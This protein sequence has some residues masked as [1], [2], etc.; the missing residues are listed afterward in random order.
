MKTSNTTSIEYL[1]AI[2]L[3]MISMVLI[4]A[5]IN[6]LVNTHSLYWVI[7]LLVIS[8]TQFIS[9]KLEWTI[10]RICMAWVVGIIWTWLSFA[11]LNNTLSMIAICIGSFNIYACVNL[12]NRVNFDWIDFIKE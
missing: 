4:K 7:T 3:F 11:T 12:V 10:L 6:N 9:V 2:A 1:S 8:A 5:N